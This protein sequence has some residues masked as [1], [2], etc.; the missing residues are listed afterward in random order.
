VKLFKKAI[1][2]TLAL[3]LLG[4]ICF[5]AYPTL[6]RFTDVDQG[7]WYAPYLASVVEQGIMKGQSDTVFGVD[8]KVTLAQTITMAARLHRL[9]FFGRDDFKNGKDVW[10]ST[11]VA[12]AKAWGLIAYNYTAQQL[13]SPVSKGNFVTIL[14]AAYPDAALQP[15]NQDTTFSDVSQRSNCAA[16]V[17]RLYRAGVITGSDGKFSPNSSIRR[18]EAAAIL[19]RMTDAS[20]RRSAQTGIRFTR[21]LYS[22]RRGQKITVETAGATGKVTYS[23]TGSCAK[24][25]TGSD[26]TAQLTAASVGSCTLKAVDAAG[27]VCTVQV[28]CLGEAEKGESILALADKGSLSIDVTVSSIQ[29]ATLTVKNNTKETLSF[30]IPVGSYF[31]SMNRRYQRMLIVSACSGSL[32][33]GAEVSISLDVVCMDFNCLLPES[34]VSYF[35]TASGGDSAAVLAQ[36]FENTSSLTFAVR[37]AAAWIA[38]DDVTYAE[39]GTLVSTIKGED[40][41]LTNER[42]I[43]QADYNKAKEL[44]SALFK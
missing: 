5:A 36:Y 18:C 35:L 26:Q 16:A 43:S 29:K 30:H 8:E 37:Q 9:Y 2:I 32:K 15:I 39:C 4:S 21:T 25:T 11:Y 42:T 28:C 33:G 34:S 6:S 3:V 13:S 27:N 44:V 20:L 12:Y 17:S 10:Y 1:C 19:S 24:L 31:E 23:L 22:V 38:R 7:A 40:G 14:S 41:S